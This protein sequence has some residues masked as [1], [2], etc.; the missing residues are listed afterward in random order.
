MKRSLVTSGKEVADDWWQQEP[1]GVK[2]MRCMGIG[3]MRGSSPLNKLENIV[4]MML[5]K[6]CAQDSRDWKFLLSVS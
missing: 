3:L 6:L 2:Y 4:E 1:K 5:F